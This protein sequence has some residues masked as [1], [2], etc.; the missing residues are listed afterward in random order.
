[1]HTEHVSCCRQI[2]LQM[3]TCVSWQW[4]QLHCV[5]ILKEQLKLALKAGRQATVTKPLSQQIHKAHTGS[6]ARSQPGGMGRQLLLPKANREC[7]VNLPALTQSPSLALTVTIS[8]QRH[9]HQRLSLSIS[10]CRLASLDCVKQD[11][12]Y[13]CHFL[14]LTLPIY[15]PGSAQAP[16][17]QDTVR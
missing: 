11:L 7:H 4:E 3:N 1:M 10:F 13:S 9:L 16:T 15:A 6:R 17:N 2:F 12:C 5:H 8:L 14:T